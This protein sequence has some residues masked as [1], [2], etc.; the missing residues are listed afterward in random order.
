MMM[1]LA[2]LELTSPLADLY[3]DDLPSPDCV[4]SE[5]ECWQLKWQQQLEEHGEKSLPTS[6]TQTIRLTSTMYPNIRAL[7]SILCTLPVTSCSAERSFSGLKRRQTKCGACGNSGIFQMTIFM[8]VNTL[9]P[10]NY[11][12]HGIQSDSDLFTFGR[13]LDQF[14]LL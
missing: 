8:H 12:Y 13:T 10:S 1:L 7:I 14:F 2:L 9:E 11:T 4:H 3:Q 6:P 5:F